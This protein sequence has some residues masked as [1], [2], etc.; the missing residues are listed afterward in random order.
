METNMRDDRVLS[1]MRKN[2]RWDLG[3]WEGMNVNE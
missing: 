2:G 3:F 1:D